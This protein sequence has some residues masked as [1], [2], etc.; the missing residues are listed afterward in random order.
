MGETTIN[1]CGPNY[2]RVWSEGCP[3]LQCEHPE[4]REEH[5]RSPEGLDLEGA[6]NSDHS[7][8]SRDSFMLS[9]AVRVAPGNI[10]QV[11]SR[12]YCFLPGTAVLLASAP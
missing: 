2:S 4:L 6:A 10:L 9:G 12:F 7:Y 11:F 1:P 3:I 8:Y 5:S